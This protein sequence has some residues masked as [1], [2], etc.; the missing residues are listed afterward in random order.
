MNVTFEY[1]LSQSSACPLQVDSIVAAMAVDNIIKAAIT[2]IVII[3]SQPF[4]ERNLRVC[5]DCLGF[6]RY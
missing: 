4:L 1:F 3:I 6:P 5:R 2:F